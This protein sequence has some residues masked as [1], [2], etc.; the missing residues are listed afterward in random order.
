MLQI[1]DLTLRIAGRPLLEGASVT[2]PTGSKVGFVG[3]NG[4]GKTTLFR[5]I[6]GDLAPDA[7]SVSLPKGTRIGRV[8]QEAPSGPRTLLDTVLAAD[9]ERAALLSEA[10]T[11]TDP[12][13]IGEIHMRS[14]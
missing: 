14:G 2:L 7:G 9:T 13:R 10:D 5:A 4:T 11:A 6:A 8:E 3:R 1:A 12:H